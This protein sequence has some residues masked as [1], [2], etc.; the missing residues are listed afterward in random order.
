MNN[1]K[2]NQEGVL[3]V[4]KPSIAFYLSLLAW[5][6]NFYVGIFSVNSGLL[7]QF[8]TIIINQQH[9]VY[10]VSKFLKLVILIIRWIFINIMSIDYS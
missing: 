10:I 1:G 5:P 8:V 3:R 9:C 6:M 7:W 2:G 4:N